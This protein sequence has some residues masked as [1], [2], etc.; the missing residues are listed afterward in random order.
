MP[1]WLGPQVQE[2]LWRCEVK[3]SRETA[4]NVARNFVN[5]RWPQ[6]PSRN[7]ITY[8]VCDAV[9]SK[10]YKAMRKLARKIERSIIRHLVRARI[11]E[12]SHIAATRRKVLL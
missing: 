1:V 10:D 8:C 5:F 7:D 12:G 11:P 2:V 3:I 6:Q 4:E 9:Y